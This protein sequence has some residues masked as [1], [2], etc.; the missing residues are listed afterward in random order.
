MPQARRTIATK[1]SVLL[2]AM[3]IV[4]T[5]SWQSQQAGSGNS[6]PSY[7]IVDGTMFVVTGNGNT[8]IG[9]ATDHNFMLED[10]TPCLTQASPRLHTPVRMLRRQALT[11]SLHVVYPRVACTA[12]QVQEGATTGL[13]SPAAIQRPA[14]RSVGNIMQKVNQNGSLIVIWNQPTLLGGRLY[15][16]TYW[17]L[18]KD[19]AGNNTVSSNQVNIDTRPIVSVSIQ[20]KQRG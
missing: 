13:S 17:T 20:S 9:L 3:Q 11:S 18:K 5:M 16:F 15:R 19:Q 12:T 8:P 2:I 14:S 6:G 4:A 1:L 7:K 10:I